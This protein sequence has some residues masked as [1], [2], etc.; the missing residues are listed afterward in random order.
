MAAQGSE[1]SDHGNV[2][3]ERLR[4]LAL[5]GAT[6]VRPNQED[7]PMKEPTP[8]SHT[9]KRRLNQAQRRQMSSQLS[10]PIDPRTWH[11]PRQ[12]GYAH[13]PRRQL[14]GHYAPQTGQPNLPPVGHADPASSMSWARLPAQHYHETSWISPPPNQVP[15]APRNAH[16]PHHAYQGQ[17]PPQHYP[18]SSH[19]TQYNVP[20]PGQSRHLFAPQEISHQAALLEN[21][22]HEHVSGSEIEVSEIA[23]K[24]AFRQRIESICRG[25]ITRH[26]H[27]D[28][29]TAEFTPLSVDLRCFGSLSSGFATKSS[30][31]D[32]GL[33]SPLSKI[34]P[35]AAGS[36]IPRLLEKAL[37]DAGFGARLLSRTRVPIIKL[38]ERPSAA[39]HRA[40]LM[41]HQ[42]WETG[43]DSETQE[44]VED[45]VSRDQHQGQDSVLAGDDENSSLPSFELPCLDGLE[46]QRFR[47][48]QGPSQ[49]L[50]A[51][52]GLAKKVLHKA[53]GRDVTISNCHEFTPLQW[54][55]LSRV[56]EAFVE[57]L[58]DIELRQRLQKYPTMSF[59]AQ[60][61]SSNN[62]S[63]LGVF[64]QT[65]GERIMQLWTR[66]PARNEIYDQ[67]PQAEQALLAWKKLQQNRNF[68]MD[69]VAFTKSL[70]LAFEKIKRIPSVQLILLEQGL[71]ESALQ[72]FTRARG[73]ARG[74][75]HQG[76]NEAS[77]STKA[78]IISRY[79]KGIVPEKVRQ[80]IEADAEIR[81]LDLEAVGMK[82]K[83]LELCWEFDKA[84]AN[85]LYDE[86]Q[87]KDVQEYQQL[88]R[89]P[90]RHAKNESQEYRVVMFVSPEYSDLMRRIRQL[91]GPSYLAQHQVSREK[92]RDALE[93]PATGAG[94]QCDINFSAHL[95]LHNTTLLRCYSH[96]D[97][98]V[99]PMVL[100]IKHWAKVRGINS[101]YRGTLSSYG[102]VL[103]VLH[104]LVN[105]AQP[106]VCP[107]LQQLA[108]RPMPIMTPDEIAASGQCHGYHV[109]FWRNE[110]EILHLAASNQLNRNTESI[111][112]LLRGFFEYFAHNGIMSSGLGKG[113]DWGRDVLSLRTPGGLL[114]K[115][116]KGW[117]GAKTVFELHQN[118][119]TALGPSSLPQNP[120]PEEPIDGTENVQASAKLTHEF[121]SA[122]TNDFK[123]IRHRYLF[124][125]EDPF[126][127]DHNVARTVT[128]NGIVSIRDEFR[129]AWRI[130]RGIESAH[131]FQDLLQDVKQSHQG[132][133]PFLCL[134][135]DIHGPPETWGL[136]P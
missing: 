75:I 84:L 6:A 47:L 107:N 62:R 19:A 113:F 30:D 20:Y 36:P 70:Q 125:I 41:E 67:Q 114:T 3:E 33:L 55:I 11:S 37:L 88:L 23:E 12:I 49:S 98:R 97:T 102:Y 68:N 92:M 4:H 35:D 130:I 48:A 42:K 22:Y 34:Q 76:A 109:Q 95:A 121:H 133:D 57:G 54:T 131:S 38:C 117:T 108:P 127:L 7:R 53:G 40:L 13:S 80:M 69:P 51:Y 118:P 15:N 28:N 21:L 45:Q 63:L 101:G 27:V 85:D 100:F 120:A 103:M 106:F 94:V 132:F 10:I 123:E 59:R 25:V 14:S 115:Q 60:Y 73:I 77:E 64:I 31:M 16:L 1:P 50:S 135:N 105:V 90:L 122:K 81:G 99:R 5:S 52:Y 43:V 66:W 96:T 83:C 56:C 93:F 104:Y 44:N 129:R 58:G 82:H 78:E 134:L 116:E 89:S 65:E 124:A 136:E 86:T 110:G 29:G 87:V 17:A 119:A 9:N 79:I 126:E 24:E 72:Y 91:H 71:N 2:L 18:R 26:E 39:L 128:H 8:S 74:L 112:H 61:N 111:G 46:A 32:L